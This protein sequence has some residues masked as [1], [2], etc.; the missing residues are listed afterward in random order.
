MFA[1][2]NKAFN[3]NKPLDKIPD[4]IMKALSKGLPNGFKY[5]QI[6]KDTCGVVPDGQNMNFTFEFTN[7]NEFDAKSPEELMDYLYRS[8]KQLEVKSKKIK[9]N[10]QEFDINDFIKQPFNNTQFDEEDFSVILIPQKFPEPFDLP[11]G[12]GEEEC[13]ILKVQREPYANLRKALF[14]SIDMESL[15]ITYLIDEIDK[16][17]T[18]NLKM[19]LDK[20]KSI[21]EMIVVAKIYNSFK[22]GKI[23]I[24]S[25]IINGSVKMKGDASNIDEF[26]AFWEKAVKLSD[27]FKMLFEP[28][29][30]VS[31]DEAK[32]INSIYESLVNHSD[33]EERVKT[34]VLTMTF[35][36]KMEPNDFLYKKELLLQF[37]E[38]KEWIVL[39]RK[40]PLWCVT[41]LSEFKITDVE[42]VEEVE[43]TAFKYK[44]NINALSN[45]G[46][47]KKIRFF[48]NE[49]D[50]ELYRKYFID[51]KN[52]NSELKD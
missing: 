41:S 49:K 16:S 10:G 40:I 37:T 36:K 51:N 12:Y 38:H 26:I 23:N 28:K 19:N 46:I 13:I 20:A 21:Q 9:V 25:S 32:T 6:D 39:E 15:E 33:F 4:P 17:M 3:K 29:D 5:V 43:G 48:K 11:I 30:I 2:F 1:S 7:E 42:E 14:K 18:M 50:V 45:D 8:Q 22:S 34:D 31:K 44:I 52:D 27:E 35:N 47:L 24:G